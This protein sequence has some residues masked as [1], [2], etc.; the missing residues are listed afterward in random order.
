MP[1]LTVAAAHSNEIPAVIFEPT[2]EL[3]DFHAASLRVGRAA[4]DS[5]ISAK[6]A[7]YEERASRGVS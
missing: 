5:S 2:D 1:E 3:A 4:I 7:L 6:R